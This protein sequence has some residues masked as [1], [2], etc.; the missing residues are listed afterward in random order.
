[1]SERFE[2][3]MSES[4]DTLSKAFES[5]DVKSEDY[6]KRLQASAD[7]YKQIVEDEKNENNYRIEQEKIMA[8]RDHD[9]T[10]RWASIISHIVS[11]LQIAAT[12]FGVVYTER[13]L[14]ARFDRSSKFEESDAYLSTTDKETVRDGLHQRKGTKFF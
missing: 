14:N 6:T 8:Q 12:I 11:G 4:N 13:N 5:L 9:R 7:L 1:M 2:K 3:R 10:D